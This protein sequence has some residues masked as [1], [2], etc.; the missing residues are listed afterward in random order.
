MSSL[1]D[2]LL[3]SVKRYDFVA[4]RKVLD[5]ALAE[6][7]AQDLAQSIQ[8]RLQDGQL[9]D[10]RYRDHVF[11]YFGL[12]EV[13]FA[14]RMTS[15]EL[16]HKLSYAQNSAEGRQDAFDLV[17]AAA[18]QGDPTVWLNAIDVEQISSSEFAV[19]LPIVLE[20]RI[21]EL[22]DLHIYCS[23][24]DA[25]PRVM[26]YL[27]DELMETYYG[28]RIVI[29]AQEGR[30]PET[31]VGSS[32]YS[33]I[34][35][36]LETLGLD[37]QSM[38]VEIPGHQWQSFVNDR[39]RFRY[40]PKEPSLEL[41]RVEDVFIRIHL[42]ET[43]S[44]R[45]VVDLLNLIESTGTSVCNKTLCDFATT[46]FHRVSTD[47]R[48]RV[49][50]ILGERG[51]R[52]VSDRLA[53]LLTT[54]DVAVRRATA[55]ALSAIESRIAWVMKPE[56]PLTVGYINREAL[57][58]DLARVVKRL[59][60]NVRESDHTTIRDALLSLAEVG[61]PE[62]SRLLQ[63]MMRNPE[64]IL[65]FNVVA[66]SGRLPR[67]DAADIIKLALNDEDEEV[68]SAAMREIER[69]WSDD[70]WIHTSAEDTR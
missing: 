39:V 64:R 47:L 7:K 58:H 45:A 55:K 29:A 66:A 2:D 49:L 1:W 30:K 34:R 13:Y 36:A 22:K 32:A 65:R 69:R 19:L 3:R 56:T 50:R 5:R 62:T 70:T 44:E 35:D 16:L 12:D 51:D 9:G 43:G 59:M 54:S 17:V 41:V 63:G 18:R 46:R 61:G 68:R 60:E 52:S 27:V 15:N 14:L 40:S 31:V 26:R 23:L 38:L 42:A 28:M 37:T 24:R 6:D 57:S 20:K 10:L 67:E 48:T 8:E 4:S 21:E 33:R 53:A 25:R 11:R